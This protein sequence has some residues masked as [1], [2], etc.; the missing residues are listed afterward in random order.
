M[1]TIE[2]FTVS[3]FLFIGLTCSAK[4][5]SNWKICKRSDKNMIDCLR[6]AVVDAVKSMKD[7]LQ[8]LGVL[9]LDPMHF[10]SL[11]I[12]QGSGPVSINLDFKNMDIN[13]ISTLTKLENAKVDWDDY[14]LQADA[15]F[16]AP[17][18]LQGDY[19]INGKVL[20]LPIVGKGKF[21]LTFDNFVA[22]LYLKGH[23]ETKAKAK[24]M[25]VDK[26]TVQNE[27]SK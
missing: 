13:G 16:A 4:L 2:I 9:P 12:G 14:T 15:S 5:P 6:L 26:F 21:N 8:S 20:V 22:K 23:E 10:D 11:S 17:L 25:E 1:K 19:S 7:G 24:Y 18:T 3:I 27:T